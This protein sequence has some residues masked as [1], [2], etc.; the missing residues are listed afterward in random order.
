MPS[1]SEKGAELIRDYIKNREPLIETATEE[2]LVQKSVNR[3]PLVEAATE[4]YPVQKSI[5]GIDLSEEPTDKPKPRRAARLSDKTD[6]DG[7]N[8]GR[9]DKTSGGKANKDKKDNIAEKKTV[10]AK[11]DT[12]ADKST[13][14][15]KT[16]AAPISDIPHAAESKR[17]NPN[18]TK[19]KHE[20]PCTAESKHEN[21]C[22]AENKHE[23][24]NT[25]LLQRVYTCAATCLVCADALKDKTHDAKLKDTIR[26]MC[27]GYDGILD[28][29]AVGL[30][31]NKAQP[32]GNSLLIKAAAW[33]GIQLNMIMDN[34]N[35]RIAETMIGTCTEGINEMIETIWDHKAASK[36]NKNLAEELMH[37]NAKNINGMKY[38]LTH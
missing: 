37:M 1:E 36:T 2:Y 26:M 18:T 22:A 33:G 38:F 16:K 25:R 10:S 20:N 24:P 8:K 30:R 6:T 17:E 13:S 5:F 4:E 35:R 3:E 15:E 21:P 32:K 28:K 19:N 7:R 34:S 27:D 23:N 29:A 12:A 9:D 31:R 14:E 11:A